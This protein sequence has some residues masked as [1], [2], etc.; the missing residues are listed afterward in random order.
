MK[1][2]KLENKINDLKQDFKQDLEEDKDLKN[3]LK[4]FD[5]NIIPN[6]E[7]TF[8]TNMPSNSFNL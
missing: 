6:Q 4:L 1:K 5:N 3:S 2:E 8:D 7:L